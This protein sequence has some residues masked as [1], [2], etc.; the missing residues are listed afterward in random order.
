MK[1]SVYGEFCQCSSDLC[2]RT[3]FKRFGGTTACVNNDILYSFSLKR[4]ANNTY[5]VEFG[6]RP[7]CR[8]LYYVY[9][10]DFDVGDL[11]ENGQ[12][13]ATSIEEIWPCVTNL[14]LPYFDNCENAESALRST[15]NMHYR[16]EKKRQDYLRRNNFTDC[17]KPVEERIYSDESVFC[18]AMKSLNYET[19]KKSL[20]IN[21]SIAESKIELFSSGYSKFLTENDLDMAESY[22]K[23]KEQEERDYQYLKLLLKK[24]NDK[25]AGF[26]YDE[27]VRR[28]IESKLRLPQKLFN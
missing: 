10:G 7:L 21:L 16:I 17:A 13:N 14:I 24:A 1:R 22:K 9:A 19:M 26:F 4:L 15:I 8:E 25:D 5:T 12:Q 18:F 28:E 11:F 2:K 23:K 20:A 3:P 6:V 27:I